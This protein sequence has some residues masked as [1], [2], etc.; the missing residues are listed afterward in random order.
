MICENLQFGIVY[1]V[2]I[3]HNMGM[4]CGAYHPYRDV[5][6]A[7]NIL[8]SGCFLSN[9]HFEVHRNEKEKYTK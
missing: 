6:K 4:D 3:H 2:I 1:M 7:S 5:K 8:L 9:V